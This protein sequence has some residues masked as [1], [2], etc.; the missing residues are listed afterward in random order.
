MKG[1]SYGAPISFVKNSYLRGSKNRRALIMPSSETI[2]Q[3][4]MKGP[5]SS[6]QLGVDIFFLPLRKAK[7]KRTF[8]EHLLG[9]FTSKGLHL[10]L[11]ITL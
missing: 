9:T 1:T 3:R 10:D 2:L 6:L 5:G 11:T 8:L 7:E 4:R